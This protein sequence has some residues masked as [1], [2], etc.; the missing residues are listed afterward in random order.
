MIIDYIKKTLES[1][2]RDVRDYIGASLIGNKC[3]RHIYYSLTGQSAKYPP[4]AL[5]A[6]ET[7]HALEAMIKDLICKSL[8]AGLILFDAPE[9][10]SDTVPSLKGHPDGLILDKRDMETYILEIKTANHASFTQIVN[11][12]VKHAKPQYYDQ[13]QV[14]MGLSKLLYAI[15]VIFDKDTSQMNEEIVTFEPYHFEMLEKKALKI[16]E[17]VAS[18]TIPPKLSSDP[19]WHICKMCCF[20][21]VC[22]AKID[23][24]P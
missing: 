6:F 2:E 15:F 24:L 22:H 10:F 12:G 19:T 14:Y 7:G 4:K 5:L 17:L 20:H 9:Y 11:R 16:S 3:E 13:V 18:R 1:T 8:P 23:I 21:A